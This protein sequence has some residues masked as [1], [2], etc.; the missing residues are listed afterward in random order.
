MVLTCEQPFGLII[1]MD[2]LVK[3]FRTEFS[4]DGICA[5]KRRVN[6]ISRAIPLKRQGAIRFV[7][8][9]GSPPSQ[10]SH[11]PTDGEISWILMKLDA[12]GHM[13]K[14]CRRF[15]M[16]LAEK[17]ASKAGG[18]FVYRSIHMAWCSLRKWAPLVPLPSVS[19]FPKQK[20]T[21]T[22][23]SANFSKPFSRRTSPV[24]LGR[25][26]VLP[27]CTST[28]PERTWLRSPFSG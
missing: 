23:T 9:L 25:I 26:P 15:F 13:W 19:S 7:K 4:L 20:S 27:C 10:A 12:T 18:K 21:Q 17:R 1:R 5:S 2:Y 3:I 28:V 14:D 11:L 22:S 6:K 24:C 16:S 8:R